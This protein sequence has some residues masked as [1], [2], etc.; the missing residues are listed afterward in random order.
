[1]LLLVRD[2]LDRRWSILP[3]VLVQPGGWVA[4]R[5]V[6]SLGDVAAK[7]GKDGFE[8]GPTGRLGESLF[9]I[10]LADAVR[11][12]CPELVEPSGGRAPFRGRR[13]VMDGGV[14]KGVW[15]ET[16]GEETALA[17]ETS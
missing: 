17:S 16:C 4:P 9:G 11:V 15:G 13:G 14:R 12:N 5:P 1:M 2:P 7:T 8:A 10:P 3:A 6:V